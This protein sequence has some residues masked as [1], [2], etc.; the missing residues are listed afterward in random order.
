MAGGRLI[1][2]GKDDYLVIKR[3]CEKRCL[4]LDIDIRPSEGYLNARDAFEVSLKDSEID[5]LGIVADADTDIL[6]RWNS[7]RDILIKA[8][9]GVGVQPDSH[10][11]IVHDSAKMVPYVGVWI[12]PNNTI[13]GILED[14]IGF[15]VPE[16][17]A[18]MNYSVQTVENLPEKRFRESY[19]SKA[20]IHTWLAWQN[21]PGTPL[22]AAITKNYLDCD[23]ECVRSFIGWLNC[24]FSDKS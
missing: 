17:D 4:T 2:E 19:R 23:K 13:P 6:S 8:G 11:C 3:L 15:L 12:M 20:I 14:F 5:R 1:V 9:Y 24:L 18:L 10:G 22:S 16:D 7:L 21:E